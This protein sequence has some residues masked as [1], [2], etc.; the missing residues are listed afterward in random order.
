MATGLTRKEKMPDPIIPNTPFGVTP[1]WPPSPALLDRTLNAQNNKIIN[2]DGSGS[3][4]NLATSITGKLPYAN[5]QDV[6][7]QR[8]LGRD[9]G[10]GVVQE[11]IIGSNLTLTGGT[12]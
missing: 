7:A 5:I 1:A 6:T 8:L 2:V 9:S 3:P 11:I 12:L 4:I 10:A